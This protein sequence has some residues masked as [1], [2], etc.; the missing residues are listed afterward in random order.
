[1]TGKQI[2]PE[3]VTPYEA[4]RLFKY[5]RIGGLTGLRQLYKVYSEN[6]EPTGDHIWDL[7]QLLSFFYYTGRIQGMREERQI[8]QRKHI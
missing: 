3:L 1:M 8:K 2:I 6:K 5:T 4:M 7:M